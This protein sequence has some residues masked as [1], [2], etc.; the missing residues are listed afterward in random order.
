MIVIKYFLM[1]LLRVTI[2]FRLLG[3]LS[4]AGSTAAVVHEFVG[5]HP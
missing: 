3:I 4:L 5:R 1:L 2:S